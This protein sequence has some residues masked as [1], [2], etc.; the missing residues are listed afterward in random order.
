MGSPKQLLRYDGETLIRRAANAAIESRCD[1]VAVVIGSHADEVIDELKDLPVS[2]V[3]NL[4]WQRGMGSSI[5]AGLEGV[6]R[7][8]MC[9]VAIMLCDQPFVTSE[10]LNSLIDTHR[11]T[12]MPIVASNYGSRLGVP[13]FFGPEL[14]AELAM[15]TA[16]EGARRIIQKHPDK[17]ATIQFA[18]GAID[19]DTPRDHARLVTF[20]FPGS[21]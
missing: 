12:G 7:D 9:G 3:E 13:A 21:P 18:A 19:V 20:A 8:D 17:V 5:R 1:R 6:L 2:I 14:F 16:D 15:L 10:V 11:R 4:S